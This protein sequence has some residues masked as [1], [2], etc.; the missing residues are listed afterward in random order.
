M[1][2]HLFYLLIKKWDSIK[3]SLVNDTLILDQSNVSFLNKYIQFIP[4]YSTLR[5]CDRACRN[6]YS[7]RATA[8]TNNE[9]RD[10]QC[11]HLDSS[12]SSARFGQS[13]IAHRKL[14]LQ[15]KLILS[16]MK[17]LTKFPRSGPEGPRT[18]TQHDD[19]LTTILILPSFYSC[20]KE[21]I[22]N[23]KSVPS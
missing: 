4:S 9:S 17:E 16:T 18:C 6:H 11:S 10:D 5:F 2:C 22:S 8:N 23:E 20:W 14:Y 1:T 12:H 3:V 19:H 21:L 15:Q 13:Q 7:R